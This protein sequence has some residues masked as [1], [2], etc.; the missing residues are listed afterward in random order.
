MTA[1]RW[2]YH[3]STLHSVPQYMVILPLR[4][5]PSAVPLYSLSLETRSANQPFSLP[6]LVR[7]VI[8][9]LSRSLTPFRPYYTAKS[10][11]PTRSEF[12]QGKHIQVTNLLK[13]RTVQFPKSL[14]SILL[15]HLHPWKVTTSLTSNTKDLFPSFP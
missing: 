8:A 12:S 10:T 5:L 6:V 11:N 7:G 1:A 14:T 3:S 9:A 15:H 13:L 4:S 2:L